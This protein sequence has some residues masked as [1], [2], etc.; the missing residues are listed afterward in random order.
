VAASSGALISKS[1][2]PG[3]KVTTLNGDEHIFND[4]IVFRY[5]KGLVFEVPEE[6][7][8]LNSS[9]QKERVHF[10]PCSKN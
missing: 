10:R 7:Q 9:N 3:C 6:A 2:P 8:G 4:E 1:F 5:P